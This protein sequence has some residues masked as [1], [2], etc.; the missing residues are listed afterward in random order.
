MPALRELLDWEILSGHRIINEAE[1]LEVDVLSVTV[2]DASD[3]VNWVKAHEFVV[4]S[5]Y[6]VQQSPNALLALIEQFAARPAAGLGVTLTRYLREGLCRSFW[7]RPERS[8]GGSYSPRRRA[9]R[10]APRAI[11][12]YCGDTSPVPCASCEPFRYRPAL[13]ERSSRT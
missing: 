6:P 8:K 2:I 5:T 12:A 13:H 1:A 7:L 11:V 4:T 9:A 3:A 10:T